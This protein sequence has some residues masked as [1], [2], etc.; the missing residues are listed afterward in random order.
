MG[1]FHKR[2]AEFHHEAQTRFEAIVADARDVV[3][4]LRGLGS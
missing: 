1:H 2:A 4:R 3:A